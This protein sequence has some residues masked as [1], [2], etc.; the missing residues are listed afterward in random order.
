VI[1]VAQE[2]IRVL[3]F[4]LDINVYYLS[5]QASTVAR[6]FPPAPESGAALEDDVLSEYAKENVEVVKDSDAS[7]EK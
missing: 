6:G 2:F 4:V 3:L 7:D 5:C 1:L